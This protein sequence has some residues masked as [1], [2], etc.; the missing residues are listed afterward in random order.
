[1]KKLF[2]ML[3]VL[4]P[5]LLCLLSLTSCG[6]CR[7]KETDWFVEREATCTV[8][9]KKV[10]KCLKC[11]E[12]LD[13]RDITQG[14]SYNNGVC[15]YCG[16]A[17]YGNKYLSY[18][19]IEMDG[20]V[21]YEVVGRGNC[22]SVRLEI[23][24]HHNGK[25]V[26]AIAA[27]AF[28]NDKIIT[29]LTVGKNVREIG[30]SAFA[31]CINLTSVTFAQGSAVSVLGQGAFKECVALTA[32]SLPLNV[33]HIQASLLEGCT[34]LTDITLHS[35]L[36]TIGDNALLSC[37]ALEYKTENG[38]SFLGTADNP[39]FVLMQVERGA[40][41]VSVPADVKIVA[42]GAFSGCT[43]LT[44]ISLPEGVVSL[45]SYAFS[46]CALLASVSLPDTL[47]SIGDNAFWACTSLTALTLPARV[48]EIGAYAFKGC[49]ALAEITLPTALRSIGE[50]AFISTAITEIVLPA[51]LEELG[52]C[53]F[54]ACDSLTSV[55]FAQQTGWKIRQSATSDMPF[56]VSN[57]TV[58]AAAL[59]GA[60]QTYYWY[61]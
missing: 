24:T 13:T 50:F 58:N 48:T 46:G 61:R 9:G 35:G 41:A 19:E 59:T 7:H 25:P 53:A 14:C 33:L 43:A 21:G 11:D 3:A 17:R 29:S 16:E 22:G 37:D 49:T 28:Q 26:L 45:G 10:Q 18:R 1:M 2:K 20:M 8:I 32:F 55:E 27:G 54:S 30:A 56:D 23:P 40:L 60:Y 6:K 57:A 5:L 31:A 44:E 38:M 39:Y 51:T 47:K 42:S 4:L 15:M 52:A 12:V 36:L 34:A